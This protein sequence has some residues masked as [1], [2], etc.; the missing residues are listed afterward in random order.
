MITM[1]PRLPLNSS[2]LVNPDYP[3]TQR[4]S[5]FNLP[6]AGITGV[7]WDLNLFRI[8]ISW[9]Y[10]FFLIVTKE[11]LSG[12]LLWLTVLY[13]K[14]NNNKLKKQKHTQKNLVWILVSWIY[15]GMR[16]WNLGL[17]VKPLISKVLI[18]I[19]CLHS[20]AFNTTT[21][22]SPHSSVN[23]WLRAFSAFP[24]AAHPVQSCRQP[25]AGEALLCI[26]LNKAG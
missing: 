25:V 1:E 3:W 4:S 22:G 8:E 6:S 24:Y 16:W 2:R 23:P 26:L 10:F 5:C 11:K 17:L 13:K 9:R 20:D 14:N 18:Y 21:K 19:S 7:S 12:Q 15:A